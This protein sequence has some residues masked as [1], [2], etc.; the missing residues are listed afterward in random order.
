MARLTPAMPAQKTP[1]A[2]PGRT[3]VIETCRSMLM[4]ARRDPDF[5]RFFVEEV[6]APA[7]LYE[8][9]QRMGCVGGGTRWDFPFLA[10]VT[11]SLN[12][13]IAMSEQDRHLLH[14]GLEDGVAWRGEPV[15]VYVDVVNETEKLRRAGSVAAYL[16]DCPEDVRE[17]RRKGAAA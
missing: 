14:A 2:V 16:D 15:N 5:A 4:R 12:D 11:Q 7:S 1:D 3:E 8:R 17:I 9:P 6:C 10:R 13:Y